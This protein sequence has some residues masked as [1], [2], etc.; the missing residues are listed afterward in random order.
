M[1]REHTIALIRARRG[2]GLVKRRRRTPRMLQPD[3]VR[4]EYFKAIRGILSHARALV[5]DS[6]MPQLGALLV[7]PRADVRMDAGSGKKVNEILDQISERFWRG[8]SARELE[9]LAER[10]AARTE[11]FSVG[12]FRKQVRAALG[13]DVIAATPKIVNTLEN[14]V[15]ENVALIKSIPDQYFSD[16]EKRVTRAVT[17]GERAEKLVP[18]LQEKY[19]VSEAR[20]RLIARDQIGKLNGQLN[21]ERQEKLGL[22]RY[23]WRTVSDERVRDE[24]S[25]REGEVFSWDDPPEDGHPGEPIQCRC[26][27]EPVFSDITD[28]L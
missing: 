25:D 16:I 27:A 2:L 26:S 22:T 4:L 6:L 7:Q 1:N 11:Q 24:H 20:A 13:V 19:D 23:I 18:E 28:S 10:F 8:L 5:Q 3:T 14:F 21:R 15:A 17:T 9:A 12:E